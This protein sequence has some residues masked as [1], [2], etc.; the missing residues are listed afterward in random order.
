MFSDF[1]VSIL[2]CFSRFYS[3]QLFFDQFV[4]R[5]FYLSLVLITIFKTDFSKKLLFN[6]YPDYVS[7]FDKIVF[8]ENLKFGFAD[9]WDA[10]RLYVLSKS[11]LKGIAPVIV[12]DSK[13]VTLRKFNTSKLWIKEEFDFSYNI[14][15]EKLGIKL[16]NIYTSE[17]DTIFVFK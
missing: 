5:Y 17:N 2:F 13:D 14:N 15:P 8:K 10:N 11:K 1:G 9:Y 16:F 6:Y 12:D 7:Y 3:R 4:I